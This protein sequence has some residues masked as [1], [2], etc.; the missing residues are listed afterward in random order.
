MRGLHTEFQ[1]NKVQVQRT[2]QSI[3]LIYWASRMS[4]EFSRP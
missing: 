3:P 2:Q 4:K 1:K